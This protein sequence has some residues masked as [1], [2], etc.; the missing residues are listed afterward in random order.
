[1]FVGMLTLTMTLAV[2]AVLPHPSGC[3]LADLNTDS[4]HCWDRMYLL[5]C[6]KAPTYP[7]AM[8]HSKEM[9]MIFDDIFHKYINDI[10]STGKSD[11]NISKSKTLPGIG[12]II[13]ILVG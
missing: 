1:M 11:P 5:C 7:A 9:I 2:S 8:C 4:L 6:L 13:V 3:D 10:F 12:M